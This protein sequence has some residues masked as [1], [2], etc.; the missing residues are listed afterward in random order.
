M[1]RMLTVRLERVDCQGTLERGNNSLHSEF[2][3]FIVPERGTSAAY[4]IEM[5]IYA[6]EGGLVVD[7]CIVYP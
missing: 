1:R 4:G 5:T 3:L 6:D 2:L 7:I